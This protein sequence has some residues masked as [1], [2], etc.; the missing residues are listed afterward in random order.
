MTA[1]AERLA[2]RGAGGT[3]RRRCCTTTSRPTTASSE[4]GEP[5]RVSAVFDWDMATLGDPLVDLGTLMNY[6]PDPADTP[7]D[8]AFHI[9]GMER[10]GFPTPGRGGRPLRRAGPA[11]TSATSPGTRRSRVGGR[12]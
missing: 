6:W 3:A 9:E 11:S 12:A 2:A 5:D 10:F 4:P 1:V 7:D 8:R